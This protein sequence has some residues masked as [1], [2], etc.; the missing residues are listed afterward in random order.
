MAVYTELTQDEI[1]AFLHG[2][3]LSSLLRADGIRAGVENTNYLI[4]LVSGKK[5][6]LTV[7][8]KRVQVEDLPFFT[9]LMEHLA[10]SS[11]P[12][13]LP[14]HARN[15]NMIQ[16]LKGKPAIIVTFLEG[17]ETHVITHE[18]LQQLG[19]YTAR[20]HWASSGF[21]LTRKNTLSFEGWK[22]L[23]DR[24]AARVDEIAPD[25][26]EE[27]AGEIA[28]LESAWPQRLPQGVIHA[29]LFPDNVFFN[30]HGQLTGIIDFYFACNEF[31]AY[32]L[33]ICMN[34]WCFESNWQW[35]SGKAKALL[36]S[37]HALRPLTREEYAAMP[38]LLRGAALRFLLTRAH[39]LL[40]QVEGAWVIPKDPKEYISK[41][42]FFRSMMESN[43]NIFGSMEV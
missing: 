13:P 35:N 23:F 17:K 43:Q 28:F 15:G 1:R 19:T 20:L 18:H 27:L 32:E 42:R 37:Y 8:E 40:F 14:L 3:E 29:D 5:L 4:H 22:N 31:F 26:A 21:H 24:I 41:L 7:F 2:Y 11:V 6:I 12:A 38:V 10:R 33:A 39:D 34:S 36:D 9:G 30:E 25:L 16:P